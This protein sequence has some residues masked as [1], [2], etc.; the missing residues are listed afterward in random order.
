[1]AEQEHNEPADTEQRRELAFDANF[2]VSKLAE[3]VKKLMIGD[4]DQRMLSGIMSRIEQCSEIV[5]HCMRLDGLEDDDAGRPELKSLKR[6][7]DGMLA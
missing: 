7:F 1:M 3:A 6:Q 5:H 4:E 2:E